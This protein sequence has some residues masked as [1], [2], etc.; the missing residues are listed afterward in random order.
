MQ[1]RPGRE[2]QPPQVE[3][4]ADDQ[5]ERPG[6]GR[7]RPG[8]PAHEDR[9]GERHVQRHLVAFDFFRSNHGRYSYTAASP[10]L[11]YH[12]A[13]PSNPKKVTPKLVAVTAMETPRSRPRM[14]RSP[15]PSLTAKPTPRHTIH[16]THR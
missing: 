16:R 9:L 6:E 8:R 2:S 14:R 13:P 12:P 5:G 4:H 7:K 15:P 11:P 1:R 3:A 10:R